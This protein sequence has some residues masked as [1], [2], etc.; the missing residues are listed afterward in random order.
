MNGDHGAEDI[1]RYELESVQLAKEHTNWKRV[2]FYLTIESI[3]PDSKHITNSKI[4]FSNSGIVCCDHTR[5]H[6]ICPKIYSTLN[7]NIAHV[8]C[9]L[10]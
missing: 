10:Q 5:Y 3:S 8:S 4:T 7:P 2:R 9:L 6:M 1:N